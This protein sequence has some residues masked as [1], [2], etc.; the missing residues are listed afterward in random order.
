M[1]CQ[2]AEGR[3]E[4]NGVLSVTRDLVVVTLA[5]TGVAPTLVDGGSRGRGKERAS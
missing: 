4:A 5:V 2:G 3:E 1:V